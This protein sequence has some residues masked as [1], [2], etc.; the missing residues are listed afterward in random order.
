MVRVEDDLQERL[1]QIG[2]PEA[3]GMEFET[4]AIKRIR[5][6]K[7]LQRVDG[8]RPVLEFPPLAGPFQVWRP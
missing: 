8:E 4:V 1:I 7:R 3:V 6:V 2:H 5:V